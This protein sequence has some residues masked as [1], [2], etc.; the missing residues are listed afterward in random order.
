MSLPFSS[1]QNKKMSR[2]PDTNRCG[3]KLN[4]QYRAI[5]NF[6][7]GRKVA[8]SKLT[9]STLPYSFAKLG[10][11]CKQDECRKQNNISVRNG[12]IIEHD[13]SGDED[14]TDSALGADDT[15]SLAKLNSAITE[16]VYS[17][18]RRYATYGTGKH[19]LLNDEGVPICK[20]FP[21]M[22]FIQAPMYRPPSQAGKYSNSSGMMSISNF[23]VD[24]RVPPNPSFQIDDANTEWTSNQKFDLVH[25]QGLN[26]C[27]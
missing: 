4:E 19:I 25:F 5:V 24:T 21:Y 11:T 8:V 7:T 10:S 16:Y 27:I 26:G 2:Q 9:G 14:D 22:E 23:D 1:S 17:D 3:H 18:G 12:P 15:S 20:M 6:S 13:T